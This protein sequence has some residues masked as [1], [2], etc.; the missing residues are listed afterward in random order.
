ML[1]HVALLAWIFLGE[2]PGARGM[3][4]LVLV[5]GGVVLVHLRPGRQPSCQVVSQGLLPDCTASGLGRLP[6]LGRP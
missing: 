2:R 1:V 3:L 6:G 5:A 4:G